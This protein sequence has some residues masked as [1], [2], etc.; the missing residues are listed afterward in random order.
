MTGSD[1][2]QGL[3]NLKASV[4]LN[5]I[6]IQSIHCRSLSIALCELMNSIFSVKFERMTTKLNPRMHV[7]FQ[8]VRVTVTQ[9]ENVGAGAE[10]RGERALEHR[11]I[12]ALEHWS[13]GS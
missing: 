10:Q 7:R 6:F 8:T 3:V 12:G 2:G 9:E 13:I 5:Q 1:L 11:S 4:D